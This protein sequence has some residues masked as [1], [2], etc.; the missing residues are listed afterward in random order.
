MPKK[1][2]TTQPRPKREASLAAPTGYAKYLD[3]I[4]NAGGNP[5]VSWFDDDW[6]PIGQQ[7][8]TEMAAAG[9]IRVIEGKVYLA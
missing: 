8:R 2:Q 7:V 5:S 9:L 4:K 6:S 1:N 3:Y